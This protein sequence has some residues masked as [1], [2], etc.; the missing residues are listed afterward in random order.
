MPAGDNSNQKFP[1]EIMK[2]IFFSYSERS[3]ETLKTLVADLK[4]LH[5]YD[6]WIDQKL[7]GG[8]Q[9]WNEI[10]KQIRE[11]DVFL[12]AISPESL[13]SEACSRE[14]TYA[15][16]LGKN[17]LPVM[18]A[19]VDTIN[20]LPKELKTVQYI[21][22]RA[23]DKH[24]F[25]RLVAAL[26]SLPE[27]SFLPEVMPE[28]PEVP[29][30]YIDELYSDIRSSEPMSFDRQASILVKLKEK[31]H[32]ESERLDAIKL[33][34]KLRERDD[35]Y[36][37]IGNQIADILA[38][39]TGSSAIKPA[40]STG[41]RSG[42]S[43]QEKKIVNPDNRTK[44]SAP[45]EVSALKTLQGESEIKKKN[46]TALIAA[47]AVVV[48]MVGVF[49]SF[50]LFDDDFSVEPV[51]PYYTQWPVIASDD[52]SR[53]PCRWPCGNYSATLVTAE[54]MQAND[55]YKADLN[56]TQPYE[57]YNS[58]WFL[59]PYSPAADFYL[60]ADVQIVSRTFQNV[61]A[62]IFF[63][64]NANSYY[65]LRIGDMSQFSL[66]HN[67]NGVLRFLIGWTQIPDVNP[68]VMNRIGILAEGSTIT[69]FINGKKYEV[70]DSSVL[71]GSI[72]L[73]V[74]SWNPM[75]VSVALDNVVLRQKPL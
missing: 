43:V 50:F 25:M 38:S 69:I 17:I 75:M 33:L 45:S 36:S 6:L 63:R 21:D 71:S 59:S 7:T 53:F 49:F 65:V 34:E 5:E 41:K 46:R 12:F 13:E 22:Y 9:W 73:E 35:L 47:S 62:G 64:G 15:Y 26:D 29:V 37:K 20:L 3:K 28:E 23:A 8:Q 52:F 48:I 4:E 1:E 74:A 19:D 67:E 16:R 42:H 18:V 40:G 31:L 68:F 30:S 32:S 55:Q 61:S 10:L 24:A 14:Y 66:C 27:S 54:G 57:Q 11:C 39:K 60:E 56:F 44:Q 72:G 2:K 58:F 51:R 70:Q